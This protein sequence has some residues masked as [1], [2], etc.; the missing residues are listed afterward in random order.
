MS[1]ALV[2]HHAQ[3]M[4]TTARI[5]RIWGQGALATFA[6]LVA[7]L[8]GAGTAG[9][10]SPSPDASTPVPTPAA[11]VGI[12][13]VIW[14][15]VDGTAGP[16][17]GTTMSGPSTTM[18]AGQVVAWNG[19]YAA[20]GD[21]VWV[22]PDGRAWTGHPMPR[23]IDG[24]ELSLL[25]WH[26]ELLLVEQRPR[27]QGWRFRLWSSTDGHAWRRA[28]VFDQRP[29]GRLDG[30]AF[31]YPHV[32]STETRILAM[33]D[34]VP[35]ANGRIEPAT[36]RLMAAAAPEPGAPIW[37]WTS[38]D[39]THWKRHLVTDDL[40]P[41]G[42][43][44]S[45][46]LVEAI[47]DGFAAILCCYPPS[48]WWSDDG[49]SWRAIMG[50]PSD[51]S[52]DTIAALGAFVRDGR[53]ATWLLFADK[54]HEHPDG[55]LTGA[56]GTLWTSDG[57][58]WTAVVGQP[59]WQDGVIATDGEV[60]VVVTVRIL[61]ADSEGVRLETLASTDGGRSWTVSEGA[62]M[63]PD[64]CCLGEIALHGDRAFLAGPWGPDGVTLRRV[65]VYG[66]TP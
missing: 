19:G 59:D 8:L 66:H 57:S 27:E 52:Y 49:A 18:G 61:D 33:A 17:L 41:A 15:P 10:G 20:L 64:E 1:K 53:P 32:V 51:V 14:G 56:L 3:P 12:G 29:L 2:G 45:P 55:S 39:G 62:E 40:D 28:G 31:T 9:A 13:D 4:R 5:G 38:D 63:A 65:D 25:A 35:Y 47:G 36:A 34:C 60:G 6:A 7:A 23:E 42:A 48:V 43:G 26:D 37:A 30:C 54:E 11:S 58:S 22:S 46:H 44:R 16:V 21:G 50:V 24:P